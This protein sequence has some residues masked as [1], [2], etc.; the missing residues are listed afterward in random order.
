MGIKDN[1]FPGRFFGIVCA[2]NFYSMQG[3]VVYSTQLKV[4]QKELDL[5]YKDVK[6]GDQSDLS[7]SFVK[8]N[9]IYFHATELTNL[10]SILKKGFQPSLN[11]KC[12]YFGK[13][14]H[15]CRSYLNGKPHVVFA[16]DLSDYLTNANDYSKSNDTEI[17]VFKEVS[18]KSIIGYI[19]L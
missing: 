3:V 6:L 17:R 9:N 14:F 7:H 19:E 1:L 15:I 10:D 13:S 16:V 18:P 2:L 11:F 8:N 12:C 4:M 5:F